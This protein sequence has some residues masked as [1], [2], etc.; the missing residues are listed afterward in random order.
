MDNF[1]IG[2]L[3]ENIN[4]L[5]QKLHVVQD[6]IPK[7]FSQL[8]DIAGNWEI[9]NGNIIPLM[10]SSLNIGSEE[11]PINKIHVSPNSLHIVKQSTNNERIIVKFGVSEKGSLAIATEV[12]DGNLDGTPVVQQSVKSDP[13]TVPSETQLLFNEDENKILINTVKTVNNSAVDFTTII[14]ATNDSITADTPGIYISPI[15]EYSETKILDDN[16]DLRALYY[17]PN[18]KEMFSSDGSGHFTDLNVTG[19][20][21][22]PAELVID[23]SPISDNA[24]TVRIKG[25][26]IVDGIQTII[27]SNVIEIEDNIIS[28]KGSNQVSSGIEIKSN[29][30]VLA[31][32]LYDGTNDRWKT[33]NKDLDA[34][35]G[36]LI[37]G[38][39]EAM[40]IGN[41]LLTRTILSGENVNIILADKLVNT[42][43]L[44][45]GIFS[46][47]IID[48]LDQTGSV[49]VY[50]M[51]KIFNNFFYTI[52]I[53]KNTGASNLSFATESGTLT[54][55]GND[56]ATPVNLEIKILNMN[57]KNTV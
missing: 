18:T 28:V 10:G 4:L 51:T 20:I 33:N 11:K 32:F 25:N 12:S 14:N 24:G 46:V 13:L 19:S 1:I 31:E 30:D 38:D 6:T 3:N 21:K 54:V 47:S 55:T 49:G 42:D 48:P 23:P 56:S 39:L 5:F 41:V 22:G 16:I 27:K 45:T 35:T 26:L 29:D 37:A 8:T 15:T 7:K 53:E 34:G 44:Q 43:A 17:N 50:L 9:V 2:A 36:K 40:S 57:R 52:L